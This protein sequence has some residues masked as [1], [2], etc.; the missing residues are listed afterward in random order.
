MLKPNDFLETAA[1]LL[2][3]KKPRD[4]N[5]RRAVSTIYY[6]LFHTITKSGA[7]LLVGTQGADR[8]LPAWRQV[9]RAFDHGVIKSS[10][11]NA[12]VMS[13]FPS[14]IQDF[15]NFFLETQ[16][17]RHDADYDPTEKFYKS[18][19]LSLIDDAKKNIKKFKGC[20]S[21]DR[22]AFVAL[23]LLKNRQ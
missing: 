14:E 9:Y 16:Q 11:G 18:D 7:D 19:V 23:V 1:D 22:Q 5:L 3:A 2:S 6:A 15:A 12:R 4:S 10:C 21:K 13:K 17:K 8:S 20:S